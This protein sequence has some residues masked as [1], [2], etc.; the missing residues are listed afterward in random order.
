MYSNPVTTV[1]VARNLAKYVHDWWDAYRQPVSWHHIRNRYARALHTLGVTD[2]D[3]IQLV[4]F[5]AVKPL[6]FGSRRM[7]I[8]V[9]AWDAMSE[10]DRFALDAMH[11]TVGRETPKARRKKLG[12][13]IL[14]NGGVTT[15]GIPPRMSMQDILD[16][17][18]K[19]R[20]GK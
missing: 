2:L 6:L 3:I 10:E 17:E 8:P 20:G 19:E 13:G 14:H 4:E 11:T 5:K 1:S 9:V 7:F 18:A 16:A 12:A 15:I